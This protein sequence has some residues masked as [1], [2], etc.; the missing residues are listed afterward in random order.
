MRNTRGFSPLATLENNRSFGATV[1]YI[2]VIDA[3]DGLDRTVLGAFRR[4]VKI[5]LQKLTGKGVVD[6]PCARRGV[7]NLER[8][9]AFHE[10]DI[11]L[12]DRVR[13]AYPKELWLLQDGMEDLSWI[14]GVPVR[15]LSRK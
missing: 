8:N 3:H 15:E 14:Y 6:D 9:S 13:D 1:R 10:I 5:D 12:G 2:C 7:V 11:R 4:L